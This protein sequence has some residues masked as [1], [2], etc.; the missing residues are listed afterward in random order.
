MAEK[1]NPEQNI[2]IKVEDGILK[3]AYANLM[4]AS[5]NK[6]EFVL[7]FMSVLGPQGIEV[8]KIITSPGHFKRI[9]AALNDNLKRYEEQFGKIESNTPNS[10]PTT[11]ESNKFGF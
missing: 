3:G 4:F 7:D 1:Q 10:G 5:H 8:A 2:N 9:V 11:S 6:E